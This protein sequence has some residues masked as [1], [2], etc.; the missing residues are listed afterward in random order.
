MVYGPVFYIHMAYTYICV[1][2]GMAVV[3]AAFKRT[4]W[5]WRIL[6]SYCWLLQC[7]WL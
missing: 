3:L 5:R 2:A 1:L 6:P 4:V 7:L